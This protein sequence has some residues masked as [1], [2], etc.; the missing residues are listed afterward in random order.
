M[1]PNIGANLIEFLIVPLKAEIS[2]NEKL[3]LKKNKNKNLK[4]NVLVPNT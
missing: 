2:K 4:I 3:K 1:I